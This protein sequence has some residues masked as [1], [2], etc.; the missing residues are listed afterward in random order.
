MRNEPRDDCSLYLHI[1]FCA[2]KCPYC[3]FFVLPNEERFKAPYLAALLQEWAL[4]LPQLQGKRIVSIYFGGGTPTKLPPAAY[5]LLL[6]TVYSSGIEIASDCEITLE[7][8]PEDVSLQLMREFQQLGI[9]RVSLGVQ[10]LIDG[11]LQLLGRTHD[12]CRSRNAI[13]EV[14]K[15]GIRNISIDLM[16]EV[17]DQTLQSWKHTVNSLFRL[18]ITHLSL[19]NLTFE[20]HTVFFKKKRQLTAQLACEQERLAML[21]T[22]VELLAA[23]GLKRYEIS[24]FAKLGKQSRH[25]TGYWTGRPFLGLGAS[26]FSYWNGERFSNCAHFQ[27]YLS[28]LDEGR[29]PVDFREKLPFPRNL[30]ELIAVG[31]RLVEGVNLRKFAELYGPIPLG[32]VATLQR[33]IDQ[34]WVQRSDDGDSVQLTASGQLFYDSVATEIV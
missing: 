18:P 28:F 27:R 30:Q 1:P 19:Y 22:A 2:K 16:F 32:I 8:N 21:Q 24:A 14:A 11:E 10:S 3:H 31:L 12:A 33:L 26:A 6:E 29:L 23:I 7:A 5:H 4:R 17:P 34:G 13:E 25:N 15:A 9:N 20:P